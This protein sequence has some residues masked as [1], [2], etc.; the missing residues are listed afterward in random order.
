M[1]AA[2]EIVEMI[3]WPSA[4]SDRSA[5]R[6]LVRPDRSV[7]HAAASPTTSRAY[8]AHGT[9]KPN[10]STAA[11]HTST[12]GRR[13]IGCVRTSGGAARAAVDTLPASQARMPE[14]S[15]RT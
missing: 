11:P 4:I 7:S 15:D 8:P 14:A 9:M 5:S 12:A 3:T 10:S 2:I 13:P 1:S 6:R